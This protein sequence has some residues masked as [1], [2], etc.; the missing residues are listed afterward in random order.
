MAT[1]S[2]RVRVNYNNGSF[3]LKVEGR[4]YTVPEIKIDSV[5]P[6]FEGMEDMG[7]EFDIYFSDNGYE[8]F[9]KRLK[10]YGKRVGK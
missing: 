6:P 5:L 8:E 9:L 10:R 4:I 2:N 3:H 7:C 1:R